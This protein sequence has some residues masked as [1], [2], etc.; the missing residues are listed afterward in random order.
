MLQVICSKS[1]N[2]WTYSITLNLSG[3]Q[4]MMKTTKCKVNI[5]HSRTIVMLSQEPLSANNSV[6]QGR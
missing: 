5:S 3:A 1:L 2:W 4:N 6:K